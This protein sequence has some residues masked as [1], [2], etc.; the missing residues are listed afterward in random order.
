MYIQY[1]IYSKYTV[2]RVRYSIY[3]VH[4]VMYI[5]NKPPWGSRHDGPGGPGTPVTPGDERYLCVS[6]VT[7]WRSAAGSCR[8]RPL[9][10]PI[11]AA[12]HEH[13]LQHRPAFSR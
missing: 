6:M 2:N 4:R 11:R 12:G 3:T 1:I 10:T 7:V 9:H 13:V 8:Q 5:Q